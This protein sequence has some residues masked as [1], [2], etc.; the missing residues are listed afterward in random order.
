MKAG[1][2]IHS[3]GTAVPKHVIYQDKQV[4]KVLSSVPMEKGLHSFIKRIY[5]NSGIRKRYTVLNDSS[6]ELNISSFIPEGKHESTGP[7]TEERNSI[8][9]N[10]APRLS[11]MALKC[12]FQGVPE[13]IPEEVTHLVT[14][15]CTGFFT[16]GISL[17]LVKH[18]NMSPE[19]ECFDIG[20]MG[21]FGAFPAL[22]LAKSLC[23]S[24][25][26][27]KVAVVCCELCSI[28]YRHRFDAETI[29]AN[30]LFADGAAAVLLSANP[31]DGNGH[32]IRLDTFSSKILEGS[33]KEMGWIIGNHG[34]EMT[35]SKLI[36][37]F[38]EKN[39]YQALQRVVLKAGMGED[40]IT[41]WA[42]HPG[43]RAILDR[44][45][46]ALNLPQDALEASYSVLSDYGN[47]SSSSVLFVVKNILDSGVC[48]PVFSAAFGPGL[49]AESAVF[50][51]F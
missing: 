34:F 31:N 44:T 25:P 35:L 23:L 21:C 38:I 22:R 7:T 20:F 43:G 33:E 2:F 17:S 37:S 12:A 15:S 42:I 3:I 10:E 51:V 6:S 40:Q 39:L 5:G 41:S 11:V 1:S 8:Y 19:I 47:M 24:D 28:H 14:V 27:A 4:K 18:F 26:E 45:A 50:E 32:G 30:S 16:P 49:T 46:M 29:V 13:I 36:P 9:V 48:G